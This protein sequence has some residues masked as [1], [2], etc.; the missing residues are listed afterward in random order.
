MSCSKDSDVVS[1]S[2]I[3]DCVVLAEAYNLALIAYVYDQTSVEKCEDLVQAAQNY[4]DGCD[5]LTS[6]EKAEI[7]EQIDDADC[8]L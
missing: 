2:D 1:D 4:I 3:N 6:E 5:I 8:S 7:Q